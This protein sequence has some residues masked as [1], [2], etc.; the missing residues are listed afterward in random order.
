MR[1]FPGFMPALLLAVAGCGAEGLHAEPLQT[2]GSAG[3]VKRLEDAERRIQLLTDALDR[4]I[5]AVVSFESTTCPEG[6][7]EYEAARGRFVRGIDADGVVDPDGA[8]FP[9]G[10]QEDSIRAHSHSVYGY[11]KDKPRNDIIGIYGDFG[12]YVGAEIYKV[13]TF[14]FGDAETRPKNVSLLY[15]IKE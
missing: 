12:G 8:R 1:I 7:R 10:I 15:C 14:A 2:E 5:G 6:W 3:L 9:G 11:D 4:L 13:D